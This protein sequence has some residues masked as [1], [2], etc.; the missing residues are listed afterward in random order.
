MNLGILSLFIPNDKGDFSIGMCFKG[1]GL[2]LASWEEEGDGPRVDRGD[3]E[4]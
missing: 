2:D 3:L 1:I 4:G